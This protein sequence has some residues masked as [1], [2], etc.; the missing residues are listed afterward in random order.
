MRHNHLLLLGICAFAF[1]AGCNRQPPAAG[2]SAP[3]IAPV[4]SV[5][6]EFMQDLGV[7]VQPQ[8][9]LSVCVPRGALAKFACTIN[10]DVGS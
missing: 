1:V 10:G 5:V 3:V 7:D 9:A 6:S 8:Q 2:G 4:V